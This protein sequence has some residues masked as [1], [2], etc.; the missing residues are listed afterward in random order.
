MIA[1]VILTHVK[2]SDLAGGIINSAMDGVF[3]SIPLE[4][5][6]RSRIDLQEQPGLGTPLPMPM[7]LESPA[8]LRGLDVSIREYAMQG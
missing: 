2:G 6:K 3:P 8:L 5:G 7:R 4:P 1:P